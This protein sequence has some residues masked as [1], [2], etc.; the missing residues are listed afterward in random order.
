MTKKVYEG[1]LEEDNS[2][3]GH[4][5]KWLVIGKEIENY[6]LRIPIFFPVKG[7][8]VSDQKRLKD[9]QVLDDLISEDF[10]VPLTVNDRE[11]K[12]RITVEEIE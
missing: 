8:N 12:V 4:Y 10:N 11:V 6:V 2:A 5:I 9:T 7:E 3:N 1:Y